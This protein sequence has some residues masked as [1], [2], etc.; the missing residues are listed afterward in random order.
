MK[1]TFAAQERRTKIVATVGPASSTREMLEALVSEG[2]DVFRLNMSHGAHQGHAQT[3]AA[4]REVSR[5]VGRQVAVFAD[6]CGPKIRVGLLESGAVTLAQGTEVTLTTRAVQGNSQLIPS[7]YAGLANDVAVGHRVLLDDG[8]LEL[9]VL[10]KTESEVTCRVQVG[11][12]L[13]DK[14]GMNLPDSE[15]STPPLTDKDRADAEFAAALGVDMVALSFVSAP[16]D[17]QELRGFL[18][19][20][21]HR[22][23]ILAKIERPDALPR[24]DAI[25]DASDA[26]M[27]ARGDLGV[28]LS[29]ERVPV[30]QEELVDLA[31]MRGR[32]CIIAT[33]MLESMIDHARPTRAEVTDVANAVRSGAD[34]VMLSGETAV[35]AYPLET[36]RVM[37]RV[38][39]NTEEY[40]FTHGAFGSIEAYTPTTVCD[41]VDVSTSGAIARVTA[42][43]S[44]ELSVRAV[45]CEVTTR[46]SWCRLSASRPA[47]PLLCLV[48][49][50]AEF[51]MVRLA[52]GTVP[53]AFPAD[54]TQS[55]EDAAR[56]A[57]VGRGLASS[58]QNL[59]LVTALD[60][61]EPTLRVLTV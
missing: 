55:L 12:V 37:N 54:S 35:G 18:A 34:A 33:Q 24:L 4:L 14:K 22:V 61:P 50:Q 21:G 28:E 2:V 23:P 6:L 3:Y 53:V 38:I 26:V 51:A 32:P 17:V 56:Q 31:R 58:G 57:A 8:K 44:R 9:L 49:N 47:M 27:V 41:S 30:V 5:R 7:Q 19:D 43:L 11:G 10:A 1:A 16:K 25:V 52:W 39:R 45:V 48:R 13:R 40:L 42:Q 15:V 29:P 20:K 59:L 36:I 60:S 46:Q